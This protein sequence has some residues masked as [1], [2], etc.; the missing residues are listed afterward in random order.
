MDDP[1]PLIQV[2]DEF[3]EEWVPDDLPDRILRTRFPV[4]RYAAAAVE[5]ESGTTR[6]CRAI[7]LHV[8]EKNGPGKHSLE[9]PEFCFGLHHRRS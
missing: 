6:S 5:A 8:K 1:A 4:G 2:R 3:L 7:A 9:F